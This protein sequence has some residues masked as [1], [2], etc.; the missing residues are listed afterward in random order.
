MR[1]WSLHPS[2]LDTRALVAVWREGLLARAVLRGR[3]RG[4]RHHPQLIRFQE[5]S[6]PVSAINDYLA[7]ILE[8]ARARGYAFDAR[9]CG[10]VRNRRRI[11]V[12]GGQLAF[13]LAHLRA[14][15]AAR[16]P[17]ELVRLPESAEVRA[18]P[19]FDVCEGVVE[20]WERVRG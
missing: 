4:Y 18:H 15:V 16:A 11:V 9:K 7:A 3:T 2:Y 1:L 13:E 19:M 17:S 5:H 14:K 20:E 12:T 8:E 6:S 10:P